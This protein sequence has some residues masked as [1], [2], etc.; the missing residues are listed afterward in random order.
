VIGL[1]ID[2]IVDK[3]AYTYP[4]DLPSN[5]EGDAH[6]SNLPVGVPDWDPHCPRLPERVQAVPVVAPYSWQPYAQSVPPG[7]DSSRVPE[8]PA[9][10]AGPLA[11]SLRS[12]REALARATA[13]QGLGVPGDQV[14]A[15]AELLLLPL[16]SEG[17]VS[18]P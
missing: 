8:T 4:E 9:P 1:S 14:P 16:V 2:M 18:L 13:A 7:S 11:S 17:E 3:E 5:P 10:G 6:D 12:A 15:Y